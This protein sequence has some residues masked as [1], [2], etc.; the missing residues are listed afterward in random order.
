[1]R[2]I[3]GTNEHVTLSNTLYVLADVLETD[4]MEVE[5]AFRKDGFCLRYD[6]KKNF[7]TAIRA[8][9]QLKRDVKFC[10]AKAQDNFG[11]D[12]DMMYALIMTF[13]DRVGEDDMMAYKIYEYLKSYPS[14]LGLNTDFDWAFEHVFRKEENE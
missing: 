7:N 12:S 1:M 8:I 10:D 5:Q 3:K 2:M 9:R 14:K 6:A 4:L 11:N 13:I